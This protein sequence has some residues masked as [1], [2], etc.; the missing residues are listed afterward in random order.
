MWIHLSPIRAT[1]PARFILLDL[2]ILIILREEY[3]SVCKSIIQLLI[4]YTDT[5]KL[6]AQ[7]HAQAARTANTEDS[8]AASLSR[9]ASEEIVFAQKKRTGDEEQ[10]MKVL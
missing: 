5:D 10:N 9:T 6:T 7:T 1:C 8:F 4:Y 3:K 2:I